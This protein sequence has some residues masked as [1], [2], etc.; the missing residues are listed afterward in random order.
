LKEKKRIEKQ[1]E[2]AQNELEASGKE[3]VSFTD[4]ESRFMLNKKHLSEFSYNPQVTVDAEHG[5]VVAEDVVQNVRDV[6]QL[7]PQIEQTEEVFGKL[8]KNTIIS[9]DNDYHSAEN[10]DFLKEHDLDGV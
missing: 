2:K 10:I 1:L 6:D 3:F 9:V 5:I 7:K 8:P 4:P